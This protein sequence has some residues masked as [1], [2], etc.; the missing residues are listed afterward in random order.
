MVPAFETR[1]RRPDGSAELVWIIRAKVTAVDAGSDT[2]LLE[3][4]AVSGPT[5]AIV[6]QRKY[7]VEKAA[8]H[9]VD[10][11][12]YIM[13][14]L[15]GA[16]QAYSGRQVMWAEVGAGASPDVKPCLVYKDGGVVGGPSA[17]CTLTYTIK[18]LDGTT[19]ATGKTPKMARYPL[20]EYTQAPD[21]SV[22]WAYRD[23]AGDWQL[24]VAFEEIAKT[25]LVTVIT[26]VR[27]NETSGKL[28]YKSQQ[29]RVLESG[30]ESGWT[31][32]GTYCDH[33]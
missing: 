20:T 15:G 14:P 2:D 32:F 30:T 8:T 17:N 5:G 9:E 31:E 25:D 19:L 29:V 23:S 1:R 33:S 26:A 22:G 21:G 24:A 3:C 16:N 10:D 6:G 27:W 11:L 4:V 13:R 18:T 28:E 12:I 7:I